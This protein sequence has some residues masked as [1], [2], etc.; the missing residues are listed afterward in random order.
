MLDDLYKYCESPSD[1]SEDIRNKATAY[2]YLIKRRF[3]AYFNNKDSFSLNLF[4]IY[5]T[6]TPDMELSTTF[7][8][9]EIVIPIEIKHFDILSVTKKNARKDYKTSNG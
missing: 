5:E 8:G 3:E 6:L 1:C 9:Y 7:N 2:E 4:P